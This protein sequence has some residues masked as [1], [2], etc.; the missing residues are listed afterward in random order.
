M[1]LDVARRAQRRLCLEPRPLVD[2]I[3]E[4]RERVGVLTTQHDELETFDKS[5][6]VLPRARQGGDLHRIVQHEGRLAQAWLDVLL[7]EIVQLLAHGLA[8][9]V[10]EYQ[11]GHPLAPVR[12]GEIDRLALV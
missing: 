7:E 1:R 4:L 9:G 8:A 5:G 10:L 11:V 2:W 12:W 3:G 6:I